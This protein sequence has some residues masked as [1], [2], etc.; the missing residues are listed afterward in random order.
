M[1]ITLSFRFLI[2]GF[3]ILLSALGIWLYV[4]KNQS[5]S[6]S[7]APIT[8]KSLQS[9]IQK[10]GIFMIGPSTV[11]GQALVYRDMN[12]VYWNAG[13]CSD[14]PNACATGIPVQDIVKTDCSSGTCKPILVKSASDVMAEYLLQ[15]GKNV[16][17]QVDCAVVIDTSGDAASTYVNNQIISMFTQ[18]TSS[19]FISVWDFM[20]EHSDQLV[21]LIS[22]FGEQLVLSQFIGEWS[23]VVMLLPGLMG[24]SAQTQFITGINLAV[25]GGK[26]ML[27]FLTRA[28]RYVS[29]PAVQAAI[30]DGSLE[31]NSLNKASAVASIAGD[32]AIEEGIASTIS[33]VLE[34][35]GEILGPVFDFVMIVQMVGMFLDIWDPC[36]LQN[37]LTAD[38]LK[39]IGQGFDQALWS[40]M[41]QATGKVPVEWYAEYVGDYQL[42]CSTSGSNNSSGS[43]TNSKSFRKV[44]LKR[45][46]FQRLTRNAHDLSGYNL[47][48][49]DSTSCEDDWLSKSM[50]Y[51]KLYQDS[52]TT[53][54]LGQCLRPLTQDEINQRCSGILGIPINLSPNGMVSTTSNKLQKA[55]TYASLQIANGNQ[56]IANWISTWWW[57]LAILLIVLFMMV[58]IL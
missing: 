18:D 15:A 34:T 49:S 19:V 45:D 48:S 10:G 41:L 7:P 31:W 24:T 14:C 39:A 54:A 44:K 1:A 33:D 56:V 42:L 6:T 4:R 30:E 23:M 55:L 21:N 9:K 12:N 53:N 8:P 20:Q 51:Q 13:T 27:D 2:I 37:A 38:D 47:S 11:T 58:F 32:R 17:T 36:G 46:E 16:M 52:L 50:A 26:A 5:Q 22:Q 43:G 40:T 28:T 25:W 35:V 29:S 57:I 3:L